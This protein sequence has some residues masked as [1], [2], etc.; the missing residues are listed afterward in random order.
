MA[1]TAAGPAMTD[2][3]NR[4]ADS[5]CSATAPRSG[6]TTAPLEVRAP[7]D[8]GMPGRAAGAADGASARTSAG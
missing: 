8:L 5:H 2:V 1:G 6:T 4:T 7:V 3:L